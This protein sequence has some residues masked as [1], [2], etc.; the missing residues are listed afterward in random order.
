[1]KK[2][3]W[4]F[5]T[6]TIIKI[7]RPARAVTTA[8]KGVLVKVFI[9]ENLTRL[10][11]FKVSTAIWFIYRPHQRR[12]QRR[13][14]PLNWQPPVLQVLSWYWIHIMAET[15]RQFSTRGVISI[16]TP[17]SKLGTQ[18]T[19][20]AHSSS[21]TNFM[22]TVDVGTT[23]EISVKFKTVTSRK[24]DNFLGT[25]IMEV[26]LLLETTCF[27]FVSITTMQSKDRN[28]YFFTFLHLVDPCVS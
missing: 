28:F 15:N 12:Q 24:L 16:I 2:L 1:M 3:V 9:L 10:Q 22:F 19:E 23:Y 6:K 20:A 26:V 13:Q 21:K 8:P 11:L 17:I 4:A 25:F 27:I 7:W 18:C 14:P 5:A